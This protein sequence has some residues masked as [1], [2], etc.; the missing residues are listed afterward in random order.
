MQAIPA[1]RPQTPQ[2]DEI[3]RDGEGNQQC[4][5]QHSKD[6]VRAFGQIA[7]NLGPEELFI[8]HNPGQKVQAYIEE[9]QKAEGTTEFQKADPGKFAQRRDKQPEDQQLQ[10]LLC[11]VSR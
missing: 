4:E 9:R 7:Q 6:D 11:L 1:F 3:R 5:S 10:P 2:R 8:E